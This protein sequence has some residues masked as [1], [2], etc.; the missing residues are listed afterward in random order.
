MSDENHS[1]NI[2]NDDFKKEREDTEHSDDTHSS[3][4]DNFKKLGLG[5]DED[6]LESL[7]KIGKMMTAAIKPAEEALEAV[8][9]VVKP[10]NISSD[11]INA[12][13][14]TAR[15]ISE[16]AAYQYDVNEK[17]LEESINTLTKNGYF[18]NFIINTPRD[19]IELYKFY[20]EVG[21][22]ENFHIKYS[23]YLGFN[24][25]EVLSEF[26]DETIQLAPEGWEQSLNIINK[27]IAN[28]DELNIEDVRIYIYM[29][30]ALV[31]AFLIEVVMTLESKNTNDWQ[32]K[33]FKNKTG[34][35]NAINE[36]ISELVSDKQRRSYFKQILE[37]GEKFFFSRIEDSKVNRNSVLHGYIT[38]DQ[39]QLV[40]FYQLIAF[41][42][43]WSFYCVSRTLVLEEKD[44]EQD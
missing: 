32:L 15:R 18:L 22:T 13:R 5:I 24:D 31:E 28:S 11:R 3:N 7:N 37:N 39:I 29:F 6:T 44:K 43:N 19:Y 23:E 12:L 36:E 42:S 16:I 4:S 27:H 20:K 1:E 10:I 2:N 14:N 8:K 25:T 34:A 38:P 26:I 21:D 9:S 33:N 41:L 17:E 35:F 40:N 30:Y